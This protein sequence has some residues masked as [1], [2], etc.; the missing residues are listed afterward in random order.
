MAKQV[1][2]GLLGAGRIG[3]LHGENL[4]HAVPEANLYAVADPFMN[5]ATREWAAAMGI[6]KCYDDPEKIFSDPSIDAVFICSSTNTHAD[7]IL[8]A[9]KAGKH[10]FCEKPIDTNLAKIQEAIDAVQKARVKLQVGFVRRFD[11]NH[12]KVHDTVASGVLGKP[13]LIKV[14][15]RDPDHQPM[16]YIKISGGIFM[17]MTIHD[18][19][20]AR[21][22]AG[23]EVTEVMAYGAA[24]SGAGYE[25]FDDVDTALVMLKFA[26][27]ALGVID[28]SRAAH[29]GYDQRTEVHCDK[30][31]VQVA[32]DLNDQ[33]MISTADG[34]SVAKP[35]WFFLERYNNAFI[36]EAKAFTEAV[37][38]D[39]DTP[40]T[41]VDGLEPVKIAMAAA[42]SLKEGRPVT[43]AEIG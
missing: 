33:A 29:Y 22:L 40:V 20:M 43:I 39:T 27:G 5:D 42:K 9:A 41:G 15:S 36:A 28:N 34:V 13:N 24:L 35:T 6:Q 8:R 16:E 32:N 11:H 38:N 7:F 2:I 19:D 21:Y 14:T 25:K 31:C 1:K 17:D 37:L 18:F 10:I 12:K 30:G 23:S 4:A 3:K 26:N